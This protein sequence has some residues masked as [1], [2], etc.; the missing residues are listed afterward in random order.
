VFLF[1]VAVSCIELF[2][3]YSSV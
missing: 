3:A 2:R 1:L